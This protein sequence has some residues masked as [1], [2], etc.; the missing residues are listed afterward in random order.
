MTTASL[1]SQLPTLHSAIVRQG[2]YFFLAANL[3]TGCLN[4]CRIYI[5]SPVMELVSQIAYMFILCLST[6]LLDS[7][8]TSKEDR[9][10][11]KKL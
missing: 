1:T 6:K 7:F 10:L 3:L 4:F 8:L 11:L 2:A 9:R 5:N